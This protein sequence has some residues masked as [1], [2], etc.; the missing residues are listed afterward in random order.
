MLLNDRDQAG[1]EQKNA[2]GQADQAD[3]QEPERAAQLGQKQGKIA[4]MLLHKLRKFGIAD[5]IRRYFLRRRCRDA[6][7]CT[8]PV[9][10]NQLIYPLLPGLHHAKTG[11]RGF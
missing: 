6:V 8:R 5:K 7:L 1:G 4:E 2:C 9:G 11:R 3:Q 10:Q